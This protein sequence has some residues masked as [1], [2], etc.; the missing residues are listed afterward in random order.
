MN[1]SFFVAV[2]EQRTASRLLV[3]RLVSGDPDSLALFDRIFPAEF[4][5]PLRQVEPPKPKQVKG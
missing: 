2:K 4:T 3:E 5:S 1:H